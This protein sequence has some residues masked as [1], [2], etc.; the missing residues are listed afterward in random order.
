MMKA[1]NN[2]FILKLVLLWSVWAYNITSS[3]FI[4]IDTELGE[5]TG[6]EENG[7]YTFKGIPYTEN[8]PIDDY[9]F[10][11]MSVKNSS[12]MNYTYNATYYRSVCVQPEYF[13]SADEMSEDCLY[14]NIFTPDIS[15]SLP[16]MLD[17]NITINHDV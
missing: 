13:F 17:Y 3:Q 8:P 6:I 9:R 10:T 1:F 2:Y 7:Y 11:K 5:V 15:A 16:G 14:L 12:Y 4:T